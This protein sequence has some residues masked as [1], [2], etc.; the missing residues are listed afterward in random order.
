MILT[1]GA[2]CGLPMSLDRTILRQ[3]P[4]GSIDLVFD[5]RQLIVEF[6]CE[7]MDALPWCKAAC[8]RY[9]PFYNVALKDDEIDKFENVAPDEGSTHTSGMRVLK[10]ING[11]CAYLNDDS[12]CSVHNDKPCVCKRWH[13]SPNGGDSN[14]E[15]RGAGWVLLPLNPT[16]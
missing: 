4:S 5:G 3:V 6:N 14:V 2:K 15:T 9:R 13:C 8:C 7:C 11:H 1:L 16:G 10:H 12:L